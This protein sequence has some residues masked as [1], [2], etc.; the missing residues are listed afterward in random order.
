MATLVSRT[1]KTAS[2]LASRMSQAAARSTPPPM[3][4]PWMAAMTGTGHS[5]TDVTEACRRRISARADR[6]R[7]A[8][9]GA[10]PL[11]EPGGPVS[12]DM[13]TR[14]SP[15][16]KW[17]PRAA[18]TTAR[19]SGSAPMAAMARGRSVQNGGP[20]ALRFSSRSSHRV[21]TCPS[22]SRERTSEVN[23]SMVGAGDGVIPK[24]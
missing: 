12:P 15:T 9:D 13:A 22:V 24:A 21:T 17:G 14:S 4:Y 3:Q 11:P 16:L 6:A 18:T 1:E 20:S 8:I 7:A 5:A 2:R 23:E 19:T 10:V